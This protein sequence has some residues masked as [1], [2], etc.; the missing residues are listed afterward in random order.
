MVTDQLR[1]NSALE[2]ASLGPSMARGGQVEVGQKYKSARVQNLGFEQ[3][4][5]AASGNTRSRL[6]QRVHMWRHGL[7]PERLLM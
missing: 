3:A 2:E 4:C 1:L 5:A 7:G 6:D